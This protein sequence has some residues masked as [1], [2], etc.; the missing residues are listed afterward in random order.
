MIHKYTLFVSVLLTSS[1]FNRTILCP[2]D[3]YCVTTKNKY[4]MYTIQDLSVLYYNT[5]HPIK[6]WHSHVENTCIIFLRGEVWAHKTSLNLP[7]R[8][9]IFLF[10]IW[11]FFITTLLTQVNS[12]HVTCG[13]HL[14]HFS[15]RF[16]AHKTSLAMPL[17]Y[18]SAC[19]KPGKWIVMYVVQSGIK[20]SSVSMIILLDFGIVPTEWYFLFFY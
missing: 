16:W 18:W 15:K 1:V 19:T 14:H 13:K 4:F 17:F 2:Y 11:V 8:I 9:N 20:F 3:H 5:A 10:K 6:G 12:W 7:Q